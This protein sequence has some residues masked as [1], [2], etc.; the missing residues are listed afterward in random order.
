[1][2]I[3]DDLNAAVKTMQAIVAGRNIDN[4]ATAADIGARLNAILEA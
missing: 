3:N 4:L 1:M 2:V